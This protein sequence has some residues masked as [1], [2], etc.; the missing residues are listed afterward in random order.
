MSH[1]V[2]VSTMLD[3]AEE[4]FR[5]KVQAAEGARSYGR[6]PGEVIR[7]IIAHLPVEASYDDVRF[8]LALTAVTACQQPLVELGR[9]FWGPT[10]EF[11]PRKLE[12]VNTEWK[13]TIQ[14][15]FMNVE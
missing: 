5:E 7:R 1:D 4:L 3:Q 13:Q 11:L 15:I 6:N 12:P 14:R 10:S 2:L 9:H 8:H